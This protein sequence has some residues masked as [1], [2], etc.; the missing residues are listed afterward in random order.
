MLLRGKVV[1]AIRHGQ[2]WRRFAYL[3]NSFVKG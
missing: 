3:W 1:P 2:A